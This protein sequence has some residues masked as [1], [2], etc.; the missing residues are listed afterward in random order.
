MHPNPREPRGIAPLA[1]MAPWL[2][3]VAPDSGGVACCANHRKAWLVNPDAAAF[4]RAV[5]FIR[6]HPETAAARRRAAR[7]TAEEFDWS[8][9]QPAF[10]STPGNRWG[11]EV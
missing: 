8:R 5:Q 9:M 10:F 4:A 1:A 11:N 2:A 3:L 6:G 7:A